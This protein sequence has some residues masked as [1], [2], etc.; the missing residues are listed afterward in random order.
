MHNRKLMSKFM[1]GLM[2]LSL[3]VSVP[4]VTFAATLVNDKAAVDMV[5]QDIQEEAATGTGY[6]DLDEEFRTVPGVLSDTS[7]SGRYGADRST[8]YP[9]SYKTQNLPAVR[10]QGS[11]GVC[12]AFST[13]S[14]V[15]INLLKKNLVSSDIDLSELHLINYT[16]NCVEDPLGGLAG[17]KNEFNSSFGSIMQFGG[18]VE[19][20]ANS[21]VDWEGAVD[22]KTLPL[23]IEN[24]KKV[25]NNEIGDSLAYSDTVAHVQDFYVINTSSANDIKNA[26][27]NYGAVSISYYTDQSYSLSTNYYNSVTHAY[28]CNQEMTHNHAVTI[29]GWDDNF[30]ADNFATKPDGNGAWIVRNSWGDGYGENGYFYLSY[31]DKTIGSVAYAMEAELSDNYDNNY[32]YDGTIVHSATGY[33]GTTN[34]YANMFEAKANDKGYEDIKAVSFQADA[35]S[36][37]KGSPSYDYTVSVYT[38]IS[39]VSN[40]ESGTLAAQKS[41]TTTYIGYYTIKLDDAVRVAQ[42]EKFAV[43]VELKSKDGSTP[44]LSVDIP[45]SR[46]NYF[47]QCVSSAKENQ[48]YIYRSTPGMWYDYGQAYSCNFVIKAFTDNSDKYGTIEVES[49]SLNKTALT[50]TEGESETLAATISPVTANNKKLTWK[51]SN[52]EVAVVDNNGKVSTKKPGTAIITVTSNNGKSASCTV[53]VKQKETPITYISLDKTQVNMTVGGKD[54]IT[55]TVYPV[56]TTYSKNV[57]W[58]SSDPDVVSVDSD[59][60][61]TALS[62]GR[63][64]IK[65][66][67]V[68]GKYT[69][70]FV[71][72]EDIEIIQITLD[73]SQLSLTEGDKATLTATILPDNTTQSKE[74]TWNSTNESVATVDS[75][76]NVTALSE[77][78][79]TISVMTIN[80]MTAACKVT[81]EKLEIPIENIK[82]PYS[83]FTIS[84]GFTTKFNAKIYPENAT[85]SKEITWTSS[86]PS[87]A[88]VESNGNII[89]KKEGVTIITATTV[90]GKSASCIFS[91]N[92]PYTGLKVVNGKLHYLTKDKI[93]RTYTGFADYNNDRYYVQEGEVKDY[94][95][96]AQDGD[97]WVYVEDSK[98]NY[99]FTGMAENENGWFYFKNGVLDWSYTGM[100]ENSYGWFYFRNGMLDWSYTGMAENSYGWFYFRNGMLD[101]SYTG[102]AENSYGWFYFRNGML[103]WSY[104]GM[105]EN[106]YGWFY[107]KNGMLDWSYTGMAYNEAGWF[108]FSGGMLDWSYTGL[109]RNENGWFYFNG[110]ILDWSYTGWF[111]NEAGDWWVEGGIATLR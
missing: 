21:L 51:S 14:L 109:A 23:T 50:L 25:E 17:D 22:E 4:S 103:D 2:A 48:S 59:G 93:D 99:N 39:D 31:F 81:V 89:A 18:N 87:V 6:R 12:W 94:T 82:L 8:P 37:S 106:S 55:A 90:N 96:I 41:G 58:T 107:F 75:D 74:L 100:A 62:A 19:L 105:A 86:D 95:G 45:V 15:E 28:Y 77:G 69:S 40:P 10:N 35:Y 83:D 85:Y 73:K 36:S 72:V 70:C 24:A 56:N 104:T 64:F 52:E 1:A 26:V 43:V 16:Y 29:V 71:S 102:M 84:E 20:A 61:I 47:Y 110:G 88:I 44:C 92:A 38:G 57:T 13:M 97:S 5:Q 63:A 67:S 108:Y 65:A 101:W 46:N 32:Q 76:G 42:G 111:T 80:G 33:S 27:M 53:T 91:V 68:N 78:T 98:I 30:S 9:A 60:N 7:E 11:Y 34:K 49:V 66:S 54:K 3:I 79:T